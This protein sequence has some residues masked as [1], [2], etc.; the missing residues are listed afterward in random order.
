[1][2]GPTDGTAPVDV[3]LIGL[4]SVGAV[5]A[6][7]LERS[8]KARVTAVARSNYELYTKGQV[9]LDT[10]R[11][12][13]HP[14]WKPYRVF[15]S[16][17][18]ALAGDVKYAFCLIT[19]KCLP[20]VSPTPKLVEEAIGSGKIG[21]WALI[22]NGLDVEA[23]LYEAVKDLDTPIVSGVCWIGVM[24]S[25]DGKTVRWANGDTLVTG[26]YPALLPAFKPQ[27]RQYSEKETA[28][29]QQFYGLL[30][31]GDATVY[32]E[33]RI[34]AIRFSK[35][36]WNAVWSSIQGLVRSV[37][38]CFDPLPE[39]QKAPLKAFIK[40]IVETGFKSGLLNEEMRQYPGTEPMGPSETVAEI[41]WSRIVD[42]SVERQK[43]GDGGH[44]MSLLID[45]ELGRPF[46]VEVITGSVLK[47]AKSIGYPTPLLEYTYSLLK[48]LQNEIIRVQK[49]KQKKPDSRA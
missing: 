1:M 47:V 30:K 45:V 28:A 9:T 15:K 26:I 44:K 10:D 12:V 22:Q 21:A 49:L 35:N 18:E 23:D 20:D 29:L 19:T 25:P 42:A 32:T 27:T 6:Y 5:Y 4:G 41:A 36:V 38:A 40:E 7:M 37:P 14:G 31:A 39:H 34:D 24:T 11:F 3:L 8:G 16:Q 46:E 43:H 13:K 48:G 33:D 2:A 17:A